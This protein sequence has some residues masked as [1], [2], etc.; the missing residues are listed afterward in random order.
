MRELLI[1]YSFL[2]CSRSCFMPC[3]CQRIFKQLPNYRLDWLCSNT[4]GLDA[5]HLCLFLHIFIALCCDQ[6]HYHKTGK[7]FDPKR[8]HYIYWC[9][10]L[11]N[12]TP[13]SVTLTEVGQV[14]YESSLF[15]WASCSV[16]PKYQRNMLC[17]STLSAACCPVYLE[18]CEAINRA[19]IKDIHSSMGT[20]RPTI[21]G[22]KMKAFWE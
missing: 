3:K 4:L 1:T 8:R 11:R 10:S 22:G 18:N 14:F 15:Y 20:K 12:I 13:V 5:L 9:V 2:W 19:T 21:T 6:L 16:Y 7:T 17:S